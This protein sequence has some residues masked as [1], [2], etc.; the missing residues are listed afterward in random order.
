MIA[1]FGKNYA[2]VQPCTWNGIRL[3]EKTFQTL[4]KVQREIGGGIVYLECEDNVALLDFYQNDNNRFHVFS[5]R[6]SFNT[7]TSHKFFVQ[8]KTAGN[9]NT[10]CIIYFSF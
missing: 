2:V 7:A 9:K 10:F 4:E 3:M 1:Q 5:E 6:N 8:Q